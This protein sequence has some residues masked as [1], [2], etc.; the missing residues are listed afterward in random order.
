MTRRLTLLFV[1]IGMLFPLSAL[2]QPAPVY[3]SLAK[4]PTALKT[5]S[6]D[7]AVIVAVEDYVFLPHVTH[8]A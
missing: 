8:W 2:A 5:G 1:L 6:N 7:I 3:P 4:A